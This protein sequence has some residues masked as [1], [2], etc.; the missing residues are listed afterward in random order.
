MDWG[1]DFFVDWEFDF[2]VG[3]MWLVNWDLDFIWNCFFDDVWNLLLDG[4]WNM[5]WVWDFH[6]DLISPRTENGREKV[7]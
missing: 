7:D 5:D 4:V 3:D 2:F 1:W 6:F